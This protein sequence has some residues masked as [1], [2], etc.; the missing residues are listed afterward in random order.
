MYKKTK[1]GIALF[2]ATILFAPI[3]SFA[4][5][6]Y[7]PFQGGTGTGCIP[8]LGQ[9]LIGDGSGKYDCQ[10]ASSLGIGAGSVTPAGSIQYASTIPS[11]FD[12]SSNFTYDSSSNLFTSL[13]GNFA[14]TPFSTNFSFGGVNSIISATTDSGLSSISVGSD[15]FVVGQSIGDDGLGNGSAIDND[16]EGAISAGGAQSGGKIILSGIGS[17]AS[18][19]SEGSD[20]FGN[21]STLNSS[22]NGSFVSGEADGGASLNST[23]LGSITSG[24]AIGDDG[25][26]DISS[27][28]SSGSGIS[29]GYATNGAFITNSGASLVIG[30]TIGNTAPGSQMSYLSSEGDGNIDYGSSFDGA[31]INSENGQELTG[32][33]AEG[34]DGSNISNITNNGLGSISI[35]YAHGGGYVQSSSDGSVS[36]GEAGN[37]D[38]EGHPSYI[39]AENEG[40]FA[41]GVAQSAGFIQSSGEGAFAHGISQGYTS[42]TPSQ[43]YAGGPGSQAAGYAYFG[44]IQA[45]GEGSFANGYANNGNSSISAT[46]FG[47]FANGY[48]GAGSQILSSAVGALSFGQAT[49]GG[50]L[51]SA[52]QGSV[53]MGN[54]NG[55]G[56]IIE[57]LGNASFSFGDVL[58]GSFIAGIGDGSFST[59]YTS[60]E[61]S[62]IASQNTGQGSLV[63]GK[64]IS[65]GNLLNGADGSLVFGNTDNGGLINTPSTGTGGIAGGMADSGGHTIAS[66]I[67]SIAL[68]Y[69]T[70]SGVIESNNNSSVAIGYTDGAAVTAGGVASF[71]LGQDV[72]ATGNNSY[73]LGKSLSTTGDN[74]FTIGTTS[75]TTADDAIS[76]G[77]G[78]TNN[79]SGSIKIGNGFDEIVADSS[80]VVINGTDGYQVI[81]TATKTLLASGGTTPRIEWEPGYLMY[82][83]GTAIAYDFPDGIFKYSPTYGNGKFISISSSTAYDKSGNN[84]EGFDTRILYGTDGL[85][86]L[87]KWSGSVFEAPQGIKITDSS[88]AG[89]SWTATDSSGNGAWKDQL[90]APG[91]CNVTGQTSTNSSVC[92][93][94][95]PNDSLPHQYQIGGYLNISSISAGTVTVT[96]TFTDEN[97]IGRTLTLFP[98]GLTSAAISTTGFVSFPTS[99]IRV[100]ENTSITMTATFTG[101]S[102]AYD[103]GGNI[104]KLF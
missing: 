62:I 26:G 52:T 102:V 3:I 46:N 27:L 77:Y 58:D 2:I 66:G 51:Q 81:N 44:T 80:G 96:Y 38:G 39:I 64:A 67:A 103:A 43:I 17:I 36:I 98:M 56:S 68:G 76:I 87:G 82:A 85:T 92:T 97:N 33:R 54:V 78:L 32:G 47:S 99:T 61:S 53:S 13:N 60:G 42:D 48:A 89:Q 63:F 69:A 100:K 37:S 65:G 25:D 23:G 45:T 93:V 83:G 5:S 101:V 19:Y 30:S 20:V 90:F 55:S 34:S 70:D 88:T 16:G 7:L 14:N 104:S 31:W 84:V 41:Q 86:E 28:N 35:G 12:S 9:V 11:F 4:L 15:D 91:T 18:G 75:T 8:T 29:V 40:A 95:S 21:F 71:A 73:S 1:I 10:P 94:V 22:N 57:S 49:N 6:T 24:Q 74:S 72:V 50:L 79:T 59:G